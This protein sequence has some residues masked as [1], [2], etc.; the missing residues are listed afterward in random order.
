MRSSEVEKDSLSE[1][2]KRVVVRDAAVR[3]I[4]MI[5][6]TVGLAANLLPKERPIAGMTPE[7]FPLV[8]A[9][10]EHGVPKLTMI[11]FR[12]LTEFRQSHRDA[13][14][15]IPEA[16]ESDFH[17]RK[18]GASAGDRNANFENYDAEFSVKRSGD[19]TQTIHSR[20]TWDDD[21]ME[22]NGTYTATNTSYTPVSFSFEDQ[23]TT[24]YG[25]RLLVPL[26]LGAMCIAAVISLLRKAWIAFGKRESKA[27]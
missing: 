5:V 25:L 27:A 22:N 26:A 23:H 11:Y 6:L 1:R 7:T 24:F 17:K 10:S 20:L 4:A 18:S 9:Y 2:D 8:M 3:A 13:S 21:I 14:Y 16:L 15:L 19:G 12:Q